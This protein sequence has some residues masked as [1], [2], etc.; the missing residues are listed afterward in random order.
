MK[1]VC[2]KCHAKS[3]VEEFYEKAE[4]VV[5]ATNKK[6]AAIQRV[7]ADLHAEGLLTP[8]PFD[9][10]IEFKLFDY[11]HYFG[12]TAKHGAFMGGADF[13]QWHGN[14]ELLHLGVEIEEL[15]AEIRARGGHDG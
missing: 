1:E 13:V 11:W 3:S 12:R 10:M 4:S 5:M 9:E 14:Y 2:S 7:V 6:V 15:A 8:E